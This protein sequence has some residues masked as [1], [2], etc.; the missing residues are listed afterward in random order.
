[1]KTSLK[2]TVILAALVAAVACSTASTLPPITKPLPS[3]SSA[4]REAI[5]AALLEEADDDSGWLWIEYYEVGAPKTNP[6]AYLSQFNFE[7]LKAARRDALR[8]AAYRVATYRPPV[9]APSNPPPVPPRARVLS[10]R[11]PQR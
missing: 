4:E 3:L 1:M 9:I 6:D 10:S 8:S 2:L 5:V 7:R 11:T